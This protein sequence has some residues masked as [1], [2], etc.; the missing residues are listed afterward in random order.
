M[1]TECLQ[2]DPAKRPTAADLLKHA[3]F[4]KSKDKKY[5][6]QVSI[7]GYGVMTHLGVCVILNILHPVL[8]SGGGNTGSWDEP[9]SCEENQPKT[10]NI[11]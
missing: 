2:K 4:K 1:I 5:L 8:G 10:W 3:F 7:R 11:G 9:K 6:Q